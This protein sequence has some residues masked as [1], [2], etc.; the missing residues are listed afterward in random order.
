MEL[1]HLRYFVAVADE[2]HFGRAAARLRV[3][4]PAVSQQ[5]KQLEREL[6][7]T[8]LART[9]RRVCLTEPG[10]VFLAEARRTLAQADVAARVARRA[11]AGEVG[12]LA[13]VRRIDAVVTHYDAGA[14]PFA[15]TA[16]ADS[17]LA[18]LRRLVQAITAR[19]HYGLNR[20]I[21]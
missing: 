21:E 7:V 10:R 1:R 13:L 5:I 2:L 12:R 18:K 9:K 20:S 19:T 16:T 6:G 14:R 17:T 3:A 8:L 15:W 4:Q 11:A